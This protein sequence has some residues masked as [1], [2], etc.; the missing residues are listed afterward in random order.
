MSE[1]VILTFDIGTQSLRGM[2]VSKQGAVLALEQH[3]YESAYIS[4]HP[5]WAEQKP[6]FYYNTLAKV[7]QT[8]KEK[9]REIYK[10]IIGV[11]VTSIRDTVLCLDENKKPLRNIIL[12]L[13]KREI[14]K[15]S[16]K[17]PLWLQFVLKCAKMT[18]TFERQLRMAPYNWIIENEKELWEKTDKY[19]MLPTYLNY[20]LTG[21]L[22]DS[23]ANMVGY[24]PMDYKKRRW[25]EGFGIMKFIANIERKK[26]IDLC[27]AGDIIGYITDSCA[28]KTGIPKGLPLI[29]TGSD[30]SCETLG[31][32]V[33]QPHQVAVSFG[34]AV[35]IQTC[36]K[37]YFSPA[38]FAPSY[39]SVLKDFYNAEIQIYRGYWML[40]WF[41]NELA[42]K[43]HL[44]AMVMGT[45]I[46]AMLSKKLF[47][48]PAGCNGLMLQP[49]W[50]SGVLTPNAK[51]AIIGFSDIHTRMHIYKAIVEGIGFAMYE[52]MLTLQKR[53]KNKLT[54]IYVSG[55][56]SQ[57]D[58]ICQMMANLSGVKVLKMQTHEACGI[59][60]SII[61]FVA[62]NEFKNYDDAIENMCHI[63]KVFK[64]DLK[65]L[66]VYTKLFNEVYLEMFNKLEPL[67]K[68]ITPILHE[69]HE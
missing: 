7:S 22:K 68:K 28:R 12:W 64:P 35:T 11:T 6:N 17:V 65:E 50:G 38:P 16:E 14:K 30:K 40:S 51:G 58:E 39:P 53:S 43:E 5:G 42:Q 66:K 59:G 21:N 19:V 10:N 31:V 49:Y 54:E 55:G 26:L 63:S 24:I 41:K 27:E 37:K 34:T 15:A 13:D 2:L 60:A 18:E 25:V 3:F 56:G 29:A 47:S 4:L 1:P 8:L 45:S 23:V 44:E 52:A 9:N 69:Y 33:R 36:T 57:S 20:L 62:L 67:Y 61:A 48:I 46:E 32:S